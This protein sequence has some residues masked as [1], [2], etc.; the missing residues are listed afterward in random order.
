MTVDA[1][2]ELVRALAALTARERA[3]VV[4]R[5]YADMTEQQ[6]A[7]DLGISVGT[8]KSTASRA[9]ARIREVS[10]PVAPAPVDEDARVRTATDASRRPGDGRGIR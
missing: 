6:V 10:A 8:V 5:H 3:V 4:L 9:M 7:A 2:D 1:R